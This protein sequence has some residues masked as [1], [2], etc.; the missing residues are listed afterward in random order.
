MRGE[1]HGQDGRYLRPASNGAYALLMVTD[2][3]VEVDEMNDDDDDDNDGQ[4]DDADDDV[5]L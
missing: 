1:E 5:D 4:L 3:A 2:G